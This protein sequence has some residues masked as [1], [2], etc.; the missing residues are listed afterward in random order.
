MSAAPSEGCEK[1]CVDLVGLE[2][3]LS[4]RDMTKFRGTNLSIECRLRKMAIARYCKYVVFY[5]I[6]QFGPSAML[7]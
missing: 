3:A 6:G 4:A 2:R 5:V 7:E 1:R